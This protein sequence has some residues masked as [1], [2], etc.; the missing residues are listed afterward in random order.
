VVSSPSSN[1]ATKTAGQTQ[2]DKLVARNKPTSKA[3]NRSYRVGG[4]ALPY[5]KR[6]TLEARQTD[7]ISFIKKKLLIDDVEPMYTCIMRSA[8]PLKTRQRLCFAEGLADHLGLA[9]RMSEGTDFWKAANDFNDQGQRG[10]ARRH[11][12]NP[13][14]KAALKIMESRFPDL[15]DF[16]RN[17]PSDFFEAR[18]YI[19]DLPQFGDFSAFKI[20][21]MA[22]RTCGNR[23]DFSNVG[24]GDFSKFPQRGA[25]LAASYLGTEAI[26][27]YK[28]LLTTKWPRQA[29]PLYDRVLNAQE[30]ETMFCN[31]GHSKWHPPGYE[32]KELYKLLE[33]YGKLAMRLQSNL[34]KEALAC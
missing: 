30:L 5:R 14:S 11:F 25:G 26:T 15:S 20:A 23:V 3:A 18:R 21:D 12:R 24:L 22:E 7:I 6:A 10:G 29:P 17:M 8:L 33:G 9:A 16:F 31:Y 2:S 19:T 4:S 13:V 1:L 34:S 32:A 28:K 27:L